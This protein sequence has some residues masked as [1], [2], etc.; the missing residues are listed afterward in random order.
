MTMIFTGV[1]ELFLHML[2][3]CGPAE[4]AADNYDGK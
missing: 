4:T 2:G 3:Q 1:I